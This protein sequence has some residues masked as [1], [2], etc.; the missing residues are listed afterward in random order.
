[1]AIEQTPFHKRS[2][3]YSLGKT[4]NQLRLPFAAHALDWNAPISLLKVLQSALPLKVIEGTCCGIY[5]LVSG[6][7]VVYIGKS[8]NVRARLEEHSQDRGMPFSA[9][10]VMPCPSN[11]I[12]YLEPWMIACFQ[13]KLNRTPQRTDIANVH[14]AIVGYSK[15]EAT[16][17]RSVLANESP[18]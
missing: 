1:M 7:E 14:R 8:F 2:A 17:L 12:D 9:A 11:A 5:F 15:M 13:P 6:Y 10:A 3:A 18:P 16:Q 4:K